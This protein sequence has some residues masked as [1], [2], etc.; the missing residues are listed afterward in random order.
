MAGIAVKSTN[1]SDKTIKGLPKN[2]RQSAYIYI[3]QLLFIFLLFSFFS[4]SGL[5]LM[6]GLRGWVKAEGTW[7]KNQKSAVIQLI[8]YSATGDALDYEKFQ[9]ALIPIMYMR[10]ARNA[11]QESPPNFEIASHNLK[12]SGVHS[13]DIRTMSLIIVHLS[14][15]EQI[16]EA[17]R[18]WELGDKEIFK[19]QDLAEKIQYTHNIN[20]KNTV[21]P[22]IL[23]Q[24]KL[25]DN[26]ATKL[27]NN[28]SLV[29]GEL[30]R[31]AKSLL[32]TLFAT[33]FIFSS[34]ISISLFKIVYSKFSK[35]AIAQEKLNRE[36]LIEK[37]SQ[38]IAAEILNKEKSLFIANISHEIRTPLNAIIGLGELL[39]EEITDFEHKRQLNILTS[40]GDNLLLLI[41]DILHLSKIESGS[42]LIEENIFSLQNLLN[43]TVGMFEQGASKKGLYLKVEVKNALPSFVKGDIHRL[44]Q[45]LFNLLGNA[46]KFTSCGGVTLTVSA[47]E[48]DR[49]SFSVSDTGIGIP[50]SLQEKIFL[51]FQ[52]AD[53]SITRKFGGTGLGLAITQSL[54][55]QMQGNLSV[56]SHEGT[57]STFTFD[58]PLPETDP[59]QNHL[60]NSSSD[61][62]IASPAVDRRQWERQ[63][64]C[65]DSTANKPAKRILLVDDS[66]DNRSLIQAYLRRYP[67]ALTTAENGKEALTL[68]KEKHFDII[69]MDIQMPVMDGLSATRAIRAWELTQQSNRNVPIIALTAHVMLEDEKKSIDAGCNFHLTKPIKKARLIDIID[70]H[71]L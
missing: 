41:N 32:N 50:S 15:L 54:I 59:P 47:L 8:S 51:P 67:H 43:N 62:S 49:L 29:L 48:N 42:M 26:N 53:S 7:S 70:N 57:G 23:K 69:F 45:V 16:K 9:Q 14:W 6:S 68:V 34:L 1:Q 31:L 2:P 58:L 35:A 3:I 4:F 39:Q 63:K 66:E 20:G 55:V 24:I 19:L 11:L 22:N 17:I 13:N 36:I 40:A 46:V 37:E 65:A 61:N 38:I 64:I 33:S 27:E 10:K 18:I 44:R 60:L 52:Q 5:E 12:A 25:I 56:E 28:F 71:A 30:G 21:S